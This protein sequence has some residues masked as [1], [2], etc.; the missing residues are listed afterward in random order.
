MW[1]TELKVARILGVFTFLGALYMAWTARLPDIYCTK[2]DTQEAE[3]IVERAASPGTPTAEQLA[4]ATPLRPGYVRTYGTFNNRKA[5]NDA[6][7]NACAEL[8]KLHAAELG[9]SAEERIFP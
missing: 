5:Y 4:R 7:W 2:E 8:S 1:H 9:I 6:V 3:R